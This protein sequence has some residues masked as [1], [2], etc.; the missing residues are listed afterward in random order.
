MTTNRPSTCATCRHS[1][2]GTAID[3]RPLTARGLPPS[4]R[5]SLQGGDYICARNGIT[6]AKVDPVT[7]FQALPSGPDCRDLNP[8]GACEH[9][10]RGVQSSDVLLAILVGGALV[11]L[12][13]FL[14]AIG[15]M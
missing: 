10:Q 15:W 13:A 6:P 2:R 4:M 8:D 14:L 12:L 7:G 11:V 5:G 1:A 9:Y 3:L